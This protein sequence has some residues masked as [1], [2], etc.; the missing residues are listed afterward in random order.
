M[1]L[2][3][4]LIHLPLLRSYHTTDERGVTYHVNLC[5]S[6][7]GCDN[8]VSVCVEQSQTKSIASFKN[9]TIM[10]DGESAPHLWCIGQ[11]NLK[12][13]SIYRLSVDVPHVNG[14]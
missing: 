4:S 2:T 14:G 7:D 5:G 3:P 10:A 9:Q 11:A 8:G 1:G 12:F 6:A 13:L